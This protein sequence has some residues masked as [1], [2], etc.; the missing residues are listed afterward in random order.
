VGLRCGSLDSS[1]V[2]G[3]ERGCRLRTPRVEISW[4]LLS[5]A[6]LGMDS[7]WKEMPDVWAPVRRE[8]EA[9]RWAPWRLF[10]RFK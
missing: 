6:A 7:R 5:G 4:R 9:D 2:V 1:G 10:L 3:M 8:E